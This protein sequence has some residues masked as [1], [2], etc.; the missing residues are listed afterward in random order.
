M[1]ALTET[2]TRATTSRGADLRIDG[3]SKVYQ[4][5]VARKRVEEV[6]ALAPI[7]LHVPAGGFVSVVGPS[8]CGK[9]TLFSII[10]G[11][12]RPSGGS[13]LIGGQD[14]T[15][16]TGLVG[17]MLQKDMLLPWRTVLDNVVLAAEVCGVPRKQAAELARPLLG[18]YGLG[19]FVDSYPAQLS[20]GMRQRAA[21]LRTLLFHRDVM[22]L[23]E[24]FAALDAQTREQMQ[25]WL[26]DIQADFGK[27]IVFVTHDIDEAVYLSDTIYV[28]SGRPGRVIDT[29]P[30]DL[31]KPRQHH[32]DLS[33]TPEFTAI[34]ARVRA[35]LREAKRA[36][37]P[38]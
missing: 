5:Q 21:L 38:R 37:E 18:H 23:D 19:E 22:L 6:P 2:P 28:L 33:S 34:R 32:P 31:P 30:V 29:V 15:G 11:L 12:E 27:T 16:K 20:G 4:R 26:L 25:N 24:P 35:L 8:G 14:T 36:E 10:A 13:V 9:S 17:F 1:T 7:D 3:V